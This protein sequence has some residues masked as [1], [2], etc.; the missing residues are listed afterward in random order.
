M[1]LLHQVGSVKVGEVVRY[2]VTYT[3]SQD[4]ILPSPEKLYLRVRNTSAVVLRGAFVHGPYNLSVAAYPATFS[5]NEKFANPRRY[6]VPEF[7]PMVKA[8]GTWECELI[9]PDNIRQSAVGAGGMFGAGTERD[10]ESVSWIVEVASQVIFS[11][12]AAVGFEVVVARDIKSLDLCYGSGMNGSAQ[13]GRVSDYQESL[14]AKDGHHPAHK[15]GIFS[16]ALSLKV[17]DT[18]TLWNTPRLP[19]WDDLG[20]E[21]VKDRSYPDI[22][23]ESMEDKTRPESSSAQ[24]RP[25]RKK[26][27]RKVHLVLLTH[28]LHSN[29]GADLLFLKES[30]DKAARQ[31]RYDAK[32][33]RAREQREREV[34]ARETSEP[35]TPGS[36]TNPQPRQP[37]RTEE[38]ND[39]DDDEEVVVR[40][41]SGNAAKTER[42]IKWLG[43]RL[44]R[45]VLTLTYPDQPYLPASSK[46]ESS[47]ASLWVYGAG[48][49]RHDR[50]FAAKKAVESME[51]SF[52]VTKISFIGHSLG[53]LV[54]TYAI[55]YCQ[56]HSP[57][58]FNIIKPVNFIGL[59]TPFLGLSNENPL[60]VKFTLDSGLVGRT[61]QDLGLT[62]RAPTLARSGFDAIM[63]NLGD[64][65]HKRV[66]PASQPESK[67]LLRIL[68]TGPAHTALKKFRNR[69]VYSNVV[70]DGI[71]PLRT[72]C[73]LFLDWQGLGRV[74]KARRDAGLVGTAISMGWAELMG[75]N[76]LSPR[77][78]QLTVSDERE[79]ANSGATTPS[80]EDS[81]EVPQPSQEDM[82]EDDKPSLRSLS[83]STP[84]T[85]ATT[86]PTAGTTTNSFGGFFSNIF[87][88]HD[89][90]RPPTTPNSKQTR[91]YRRSQTIKP[92]G[93]DSTSA[94][95][96]STSRV[97]SGH[98]LED[99]S[100]GVS[101]PPKTTF[102]ES[103]HDLINPKIPDVEYILDPAKRPRTIFHDRVY[104]PRDI[105]PPPLKKRP[106]GA[107][108][109][110]RSLHRSHTGVSQSSS[111]SNPY[112]AINH[113]DS[114]ASAKDYD[115]TARTGPRKAPNEVVDGSNMKVEEKIARAYHRDLS[116]RK[117]LVKLEP[118]AHNNIIVR[119]M[120]ANAYG[121][122][123]VHHIVDAHFS[124][125][126]AARMRDDEERSDERALD[127]NLPPDQHGGETKKDADSARGTLQPSS[128]PE[129]RSA[130]ESRE[131]EDAV[132]DL[133]S[134]PTQMHLHSS[135]QG[136]SQGIASE[137]A[138]PTRPSIDRVDSVSWSD[139]D[140]LD[141]DIGS[142]TET[143]TDHGKDKGKDTGKDTVTSPLGG[144]NWT[145]KIVGKRKTPV[146]S[147]PP[148]PAEESKKADKA[149][150]E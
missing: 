103:A 150:K 47:W 115:D 74:E 94:E 129:K 59:A 142:D 110:R 15:R 18:A 43:K 117:V 30:I 76:Q 84:Y 101:A 2:T 138:E 12:S 16:R 53:G 82:A 118:D 125:S 14:G 121:W 92:G 136:K 5:P 28:G 58:F 86:P 45:Y 13:P 49:E 87:R 37:S 90:A 132:P 56:K 114:L 52:K 106:T 67:P 140:W 66:K 22:P 38:Q 127:I 77:R 113:E 78:P 134:S 147:P 42:G 62:W 39:D 51:R 32:A 120:F 98:E 25:T 54:Q 104:H 95:S 3:P 29:L 20:R 107:L 148:S 112:P 99:D 46:H 75:T 93:G 8:A 123:V 149:K 85:E 50:H 63:S 72:S 137:S 35:Q 145:E 4:R 19:G 41:F 124:D 69:T 100:S 55:A 34:A 9:V 1:L 79:R 10:N 96:P 89:G 73:L 6:G 71:V 105:P 23:V 102:F 31:T 83:I 44:A 144:W 57:E 65:A 33:R 64:M 68:P 70:N 116:W 27:Q 26:K 21:R 17:E 97:T 139:R 126:A 11:L 7:E 135:P 119:R 128:G 91:I 109:L 108:S 143:P 141:S 80:H 81:H 24:E 130:S 88:S 61:G 133:P 122:P 131:A 40:G 36:G 48:E 60:Y 146:H 111:S